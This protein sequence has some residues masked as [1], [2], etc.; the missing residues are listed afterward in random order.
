[1]HGANMGFSAA[2]YLR[3]GGFPPLATAEDH[4][5]WRRLGDIGASRVH[6]PTCPVVTSARSHARAPHG[7]AG[8]LDDLQHRL[9]EQ[10]EGVD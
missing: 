3:A 7:F 6:D 10:L 4:G 2:A 8:A 1:M 9:G 5:L